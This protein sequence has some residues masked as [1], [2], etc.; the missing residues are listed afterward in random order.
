MVGLFQAAATRTAG[1]AAVNIADLHPA[2]H[3]SYLVMMYISVYPIA[4]SMRRTNV[5]EER[6]LGVY[7]S[8]E[9]E[10]EDEDSSEKSTSDKEPSYVGSHLRRQLGF[11]LWYIFLGVFLIAIIEG[12][13]LDTT[14]DIGFTMWAILFEV[15][16]AYGT[17]GLSLGYP[18]TSTSFSAQFKTLSKLIIIAMMIRGRHRG[19][20]YALDRAVLL[21][22]EALHKK[23]ADDAARRMRRRSSAASAVSGYTPP[24]AVFRPETG[25]SSGVAWRGQD[26]AQRRDSTRRGTAVSSI[27]NANASIN[28]AA[29]ATE[30]GSAPIPVPG[31]AQG[32]SQGQA[33]GQSQSQSY[34]SPP[35][36]RSTGNSKGNVERLGSSV[37]DVSPTQVCGAAGGGAGDGATDTSPSQRMPVSRNVERLPTH[38]EHEH[39]EEGG[40]GHGQ[41]SG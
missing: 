23:E 38:E 9:D 39:E 8:P 15:V 21:P 22:S 16:S 27:A 36:P 17:V 6:S 25:L 28:T 1:L 32:K 11:D 18:G 2:I 26:W 13:R 34:A 33:H 19:L 31:Q 20:P 30:T 12:S 10:L 3:V 4:I 5:Y 40:H 24:G 41:G 29:G 14:T 35:S 37:D 7:Y